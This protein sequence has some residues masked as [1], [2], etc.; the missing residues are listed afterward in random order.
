MSGPADAPTTAGTQYVDAIATAGPSGLAGITCSTDNAPN[1]G[2]PGASAQIPVS[3]LGDH[4]VRCAAENN[5]ADPSG[6]RA[7]SPTESS[8]VSIREP[9]IAGI[10]FTRIVDKLRCSKVKERVKVPARWVTVRRH[11]HRIRV[12]R[13]AHTKIVRVTRCHPRTKRERIKVWK[14]VVRHGRKVRVRRTKVVRVVL[15]PRAINHI[16]RRVGHGH[17]TTV[18]GWLGT[19]AGTALAGQEVVV[20]AAANNGLGKFRTAAVV[21]TRADGSWTARL[22]P[23]PS[24]LIEAIYSG[25]AVMEPATS[26]QVRLIVPAKIKLHVS[27]TYS[28]WGGTI[29]ISGRVLGGYLPRGKLL[30]LR[31]GADGVSGTVGIPNITRKGGFRT[32]WT[33]AQGSGRVRYWF[34]VS[35]LPEADYPYASASSPRRTVTV[36]P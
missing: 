4:V 35:T 14:T 21:T 8:A 28:H 24:R 15:L 9:A 3:G 23:G 34:A 27:P 2:Y 1:Q 31:I 12:H 25:D 11:H 22:R 30:R 10:A 20:L 7:W 19:S 26:G 32:T 36:G 18:S 29:H 33:F 16:T 13:R 6:N 5:A 17:A